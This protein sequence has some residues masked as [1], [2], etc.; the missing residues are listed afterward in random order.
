MAQLAIDAPLVDKGYEQITLTGVDDLT[1]PDG[2]WIADVQAEVQNI[3][4]RFDTV[5]PTA[6]IGALL[7]VGD[8]PHRI[9]GRTALLAAEF[10][11]AVAGAK[12]NVQYWGG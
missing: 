4:F 5:A 10:I 12:L 2:A 8:L 1:V 11:Q 7:V 6:S 9:V 3:R